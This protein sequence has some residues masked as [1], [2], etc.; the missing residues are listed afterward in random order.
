MGC[1][2]WQAKVAA[3]SGI[4]DTTPLTRYSAGECGLVMAL[5]RLFSSRSFSQA[6]CANPTKKRCSGFI[7]SIGLSCWSRVAS[8]QA[9]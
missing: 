3:N 9:I 5:T 7:P 4:F 6:H 8:F 1:P 2:T